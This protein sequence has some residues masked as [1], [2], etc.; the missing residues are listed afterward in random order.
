MKQYQIWNITA[1]G[2]L[3]TIPHLA[4]TVFFTD[5]EEAKRALA[6]CYDRQD[7]LKITPDLRME[8]EIRE[9]SDGI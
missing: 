4:L 2:K 6:E 9:V 7:R 8:Y 3:A 1:E 5:Q